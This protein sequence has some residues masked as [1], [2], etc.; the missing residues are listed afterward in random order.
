MQV[1]GG[2]AEPIA[3]AWAQSGSA[4]SGITAYGSTPARRKKRPKTRLAAL[5][6]PA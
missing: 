4:I 3:K 6:A 1:G 2:T 5:L